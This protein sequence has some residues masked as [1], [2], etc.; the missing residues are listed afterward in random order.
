MRNKNVV[1]LLGFPL[2]LTCAE[3]GVKETCR[4][5]HKQER[6]SPLKTKGPDRGAQERRGWNLNPLA[7]GLRRGP[8]AWGGRAGKPQLAQRVVG[9]T[10][11]TEAQ[12][13]V[14][15]PLPSTGASNE[16]PTLQPHMRTADAS[17]T[18]SGSG[19]R[20]PGRVTA[21]HTSTSQGYP[22]AA[23]GP[24]S[25]FHSAADTSRDRVKR[26]RGRKS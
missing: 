23:R 7:P 8:H 2:C 20:S 9:S 17:P 12:D 10:G 15:S 26:H 13:T 25:T 4:S 3:L 14:R 18:V 5:F 11:T 24:Q 19:M 1:R 16:A 22:A 21:G 6:A